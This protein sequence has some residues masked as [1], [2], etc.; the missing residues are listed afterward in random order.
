VRI[1]QGCVFGLKLISRVG[2]GLIG[3]VLFF[4]SFQHYFGLDK[5]TPSEKAW[6]NGNIVAILQLGCL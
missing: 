2:R 5:M 1:N 3:G 4:D 6:L